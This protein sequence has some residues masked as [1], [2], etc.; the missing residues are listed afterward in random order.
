MDFK[1]SSVVLDLFLIGHK[2]KKTELNLD[3]E[4]IAGTQ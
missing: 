3:M 4:N 2:D 1:S